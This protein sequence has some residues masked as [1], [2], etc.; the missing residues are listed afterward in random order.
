MLCDQVTGY[1]RLYVLAICCKSVGHQV[2]CQTSGGDASKLWR[3]RAD[4]DTRRAGQ[5]ISGSGAVVYKTY[6]VKPSEPDPEMDV[7]TRCLLYS[8]AFAFNSK[9]MLQ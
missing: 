3:R 1:D 8:S 6:Q 5:N 4:R 2:E 7:R 9:V